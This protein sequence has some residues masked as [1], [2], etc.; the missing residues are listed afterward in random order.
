MNFRLEFQVALRYLQSRKK[1]AFISIISFLSLVGIMLGVAALIVVM[2]VMNG[3]RTELTKKLKGFNSDVMVRNFDDRISNYVESVR[4]MSKLECVS[5]AIPVISEQSLLINGDRA[6]GTMIKALRSKDIKRYTFLKKK[7][8][9]RDNGI[10]LGVRLAKILGVR[11]GDSV[12]LVSTHFN[13]TVIGALP[14]IKDFYVEG[15]FN[16]GLSEYDSSYAIISLAAGQKMFDMKGA[17]NS[18]EVFLMDGEDPEES[19]HLISKK[20]GN[21]YQVYDWRKLNQ[22]LFDALK[23][24][25]V[26]MFIIL[27]FIII[28]AA[29][30]IIS[31]L[32]MLVTDKVKEIAIL[33]TIGFSKGSIMRLF[34]YSGMILGVVGTVL[35]VILGISIAYNIDAIK[36]FFSMISGTTIFDP[37]IYYLDVLPSKIDKIDVI[38][39]ILLSLTVSFLA[40]LY[41]SYKASRMSPAEGLKND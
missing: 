2:S 39:V 30:N 36:N 41:P 1:D 37:I 11:P 10:I 21:Q 25:R 13:T 18:I 14:K 17:V 40:T 26:V 24:E 12:K 38:K 27:T 15:L 34:L 16:S 4:S 19:S 8:I 31:S 6:T 9:S 23:T 3:Y 29:F 28:V 22:S 7:K 20:L 5:S 32:T 35:G 33:R